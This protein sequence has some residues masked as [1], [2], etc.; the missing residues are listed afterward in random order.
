TNSNE[1]QVFAFKIDYQ[2]PLD[3]FI[4]NSSINL[5]V[6]NLDG[7]EE[8]KI[9]FQVKDKSL[10]NTFYAQLKAMYRPYVYD[11]LYQLTP[12]MYDN[13]GRLISTWAYKKFNNSITVG[14]KHDYRY[15]Q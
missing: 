4:T 1:N 12:H 10:K 7:L 15:S 6:Q 14:L 3:K 9:L 5:Y 8:G 2:T 13:Y 11:S